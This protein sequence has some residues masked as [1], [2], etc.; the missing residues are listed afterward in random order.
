VAAPGVSPKGRLRQKKK[1]VESKMIIENEVYVTANY[2]T[3]IVVAYGAGD[4]SK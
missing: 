2:V 3:Q 1:E 4:A